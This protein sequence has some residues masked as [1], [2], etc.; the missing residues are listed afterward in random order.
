[1]QNLNEEFALALI[2]IKQN[3][4]PVELQFQRFT[5]GYLLNESVLQQRVEYIEDT[6]DEGRCVKE[7]DPVQSHWHAVLHCQ[8]RLADNTLRWAA[9]CEM[10]HAESLYRRFRSL[11]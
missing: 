3:L 5:I 2:L 8:H 4:Q 9:F 11:T 6:L 10:H 7:V 1:M